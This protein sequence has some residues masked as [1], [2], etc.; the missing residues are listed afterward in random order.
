MHS[1]EAAPMMEFI[2]W[3]RARDI[4]LAERSWGE[5]RPL[6]VAKIEQLADEFAQERASHLPRCTCPSNFE[7]AP[8]CPRHG[9]S[10]GGQP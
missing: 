4:M 3:L 1:S 7:I 8:R 5:Y 2:S 10:P 6:E 9:M